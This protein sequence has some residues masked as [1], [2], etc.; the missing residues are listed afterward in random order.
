[1][2]FNGAAI[3]LHPEVARERIREGAARALH[4]LAEIEPFTIA[5][6]YELVSVLRPETSGGP[7]PSATVQSE[8][9]LD[10]LRQPRPHEVS[11]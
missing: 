11:G 7:M 1:V 3:H 10:L 2:H 4:R 5:P 9:L 8:D 6:P